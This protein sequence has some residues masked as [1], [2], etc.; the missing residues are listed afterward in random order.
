MDHAHRILLR[1]TH[2]NRR[3]SRSSER[4]HIAWAFPREALVF[5]PEHRR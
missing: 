3:A 5:C 1:T 4:E 2:L